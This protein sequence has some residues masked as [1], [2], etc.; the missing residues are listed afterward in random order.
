[1]NFN[2]SNL[3]HWFTYAKNKL[4]IHVFEDFNPLSIVE[5]YQFSN[6]EQNLTGKYLYIIFLTEKNTINTANILL[7]FLSAN[8]FLFTDTFFAHSKK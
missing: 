5:N 6:S 1:V 3:R 7:Y 4:K 2:L 8:F